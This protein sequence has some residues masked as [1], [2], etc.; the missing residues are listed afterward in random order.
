MS[1]SIHTTTNRSI[2]K[3]SLKAYSMLF[4]LGLLMPLCSFAQTDLGPYH[5]LGN[6]SLELCI[7]SGASDALVITLKNI[8]AGDKTDVSFE[9]V[10]PN[11]GAIMPTL[12]GL[13]SVLIPGQATKDEVY[14]DDDGDGKLFEKRTGNLFVQPDAQF[15]ENGNPV[16]GTEENDQTDSSPGNKIRGILRN[17]SG[18]KWQSFKPNEVARFKLSLSGNPPE[19][20]KIRVCWS[21]A[22]AQPNVESKLWGHSDSAGDAVVETEVPGICQ[23]WNVENAAKQTFIVRNKVA[24]KGRDVRIV[25]RRFPNNDTQGIPEI[26]GVNLNGFPFRVDD[27]TPAN[28]D[29]QSNVGFLESDG[30]G[31]KVEDKLTP[32]EKETGIQENNGDPHNCRLLLQRN[33]KDGDEV[34]VTLILSETPNL[35][36]GESLK[37]KFY[38]SSQIKESSNLY[39]TDANRHVDAIGYFP[40]PDAPGGFQ[41]PVPTLGQYMHHTFVNESGNTV[42]K[43]DLNAPEGNLFL[44]SYLDEEHMGSE[45]QICGDRA[46]LSLD[47]PLE[48]GDTLDVYSIMR[49]QSLPETTMLIQINGDAGC[50]C[51]EPDACNYSET[52]TDNADCL[53]WDVCDVCGGSGTLAGCMDDSAC[54][55]NPAADCDNGSCTYPGCSDPDACNYEENAGCG[56]E[57]LFLDACAECGGLGTVPGCTN[58][59]ACNYY[60]EANCNDGSCD[61]SCIGCTDSLACNYSTAAII[62]DGSCCLENCLNLEMTDSFGDG[63]GGIHY[64]ILD[65]QTQELLHYGSLLDGFSDI[66]LLCLEEGCYNLQVEGGLYEEDVT[67]TLSG[68]NGNDLFGTAPAVVGFAVGSSICDEGCVNPLACNYDPLA[69]LDDGSCEFDSCPAVSG[70]I[71][72]FACNYDPLANIDDGSCLYLDACGNCGGSTWSSGCTDSSACNYDDEALCDDGTC[73]YLNECGLCDTPCTEGCMDPA[74]CNYDPLANIDLGC[75]YPGDSCDDGNLNTISDVYDGECQCAGSSVG[76]GC[77]D[78]TACNFNPE[79]FIDPGV[80]CYDSCVTIEMTDSG[81]DAWNGA[82]LVIMELFTGETTELDLESASEG[83]GLTVGQES[84]CLPESCYSVVVGGGE[85]NQDISWSITYGDTVITGIAPET[86]FFSTGL[87]NCFGCNNP[88]ACNYD[89]PPY[90]E[91]PWFDDWHY[92]VYEDPCGDCDGSGT[93]AGCTDPNACNYNQCADCDNG[94]CTYGLGCTTPLACNYDPTADCDDGTCEYESC[95]GCTYPEATN[96]NPTASIDDGSCLMA[97]QN[98]CPADLNG[99][100]LVGAGDLLEL[101]SVWGSLCDLPCP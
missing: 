78:P 55:F 40:I 39:G 52:D 53:Y 11:A 100:N 84:L 51:N 41:A 20:S 28:G 99:D 37:V 64:S 74:A 2:P 76:V 31:S 97:A 82:T 93:I 17:G 50:N 63:W 65:G 67:W 94:S 69:T 80:C 24:K 48:V 22:P 75:A 85:F 43:V 101:L 12:S 87:E 61:F 81:G 14:V 77:T 62:D 18:G 10:P 7:P 79:A 26:Q 59:D 45:I 35:G 5:E 88:E 60:S 47:S 36:P 34:E 71:V 86:H 83:D 70:C 23:V 13:K 96:F 90:E 29:P 57:C 27:F 89:P 15:D 91:L 98:C 9:L 30:F 25:L 73:L 21:T 54:N 42:H 1:T 92:C 56:A 32:K 66:H 46:S 6:G 16:A 49:F 33:L 19:G 3:Y 8:S 68:V 58:E 38:F 72:Q 4:L 44:N 95:L